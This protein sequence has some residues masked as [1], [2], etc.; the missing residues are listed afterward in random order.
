MYRIV[1]LSFVLATLFSCK[2]Q[3]QING[4]L[5]HAPEQYYNIDEMAFS[6]PVF[7]DSGRVNADGQFKAQF[8]NIDEEAL[9]RIRFE[10]GK[11]ILLA[12]KPGEVASIKGNWDQ[13]ENYTLQGSKSS[14]TLKGFL[15]NL[16]ENINDIRTMQVI[17]DTLKGRKN[18]SDSLIASAESDI[19]NINARF[20]Q[21]VKTF[22]DTTESVA[23]ALFAVNMIKPA[24]EMPFLT[25]FYKN[26]YSF[27]IKQNSKTICRQLFEKHTSCYTSRSR[28]RKSGTRF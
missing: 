4:T 26:K 23:S 25:S 13:L 2:N 19:K 9:Y 20:M 15:V 17:I 3:T 11:Y 16:R 1:I 14:E 10:K 5:E 22:A 28:T 12:L 8:K 7:V 6:G 24:Y 27:F 21:Y 18:T